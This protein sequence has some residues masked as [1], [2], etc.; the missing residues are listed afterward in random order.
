MATRSTTTTTTTGTTTE[1]SS[2]TTTSSAA[3]STTTGPASAAADAD[4]RLLS[5]LLPTANIP[6]TSACCTWNPERISCSLGSAAAVVSLNVSGLALSGTVPTELRGLTKLQTLDISANRFSGAFPDFLRDLT[7][8]QEIRANDN[9]FSGSVPDYLFRLPLVQRISLAGNQFSG[10]LPSFDRASSTV[11]SVDLSNNQLAGVIPSTIDGLSNVAELSLSNNRLSGALPTTLGNMAYLTAL[12]LDNNILTGV[13]PEDLGRTRLTTLNITGNYFTGPLPSSVYSIAGL[14]V[15]NNCF[16]TGDIDT[17]QLPDRPT[18]SQKSNSDCAL[19]IATLSV[20]R[21]ATTS[22]LTGITR[23]LTSSTKPAN[24]DV[25]STLFVFPTQVGQNTPLPAQSTPDTGLAP[26]ILP[27]SILAAVAPLT[28]ALAV[29]LIVWGV[30][31]RRIQ[32]DGV[33]MGSGSE[34]ASMRHLT[35]PETNDPYVPRHSDSTMRFHHRRST[36][37]SRPMEDP[38]SPY[39]AMMLQPLSPGA[40]S[41]TPSHLSPWNPN[42]ARYPAPVAA[43]PRPGSA[44]AGAGAYAHRSSPALGPPVPT[45]AEEPEGSFNSDEVVDVSVEEAKA[46]NVEQAM[47]YLAFGGVAQPILDVLAA[48]NINGPGLLALTDNKL[49][50]MGVSSSAARNVLLTLVAQIGAAPVQPPVP[51]AEPAPPQIPQA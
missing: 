42:T 1:E 44:G 28:L 31:I 39:A 9:S 16:Q 26:W 20:S 15:G 50:S 48:N 36:S 27:V 45:I 24:S 30:R 49:R 13:V 23:T 29:V 40:A 33:I 2:T 8:L 10:A 41:N 21:S 6:A 3:S 7:S 43:S 51:A 17:A 4:C 19:F 25:T 12:R 32:T 18:I 37:G 46:W 34:T 5:G 47:D 14:S 38:T 22:R 11:V 35:S